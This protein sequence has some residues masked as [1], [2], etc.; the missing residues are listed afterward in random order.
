MDD[1]LPPHSPAITIEQLLV[2]D[3]I[4][5]AGSFSAAARALRRTQSAVSYH[6]AA[7]EGQLGVA[8]FDRSHRLPTLTVAGEAMLVHARRVLS[9]LN[10]LRGA[11][12]ALASGLEPR[13]FLAVNTLFPA[14]VLGEVM[15]ELGVRFPSV[16][17]TTRTSASRE[18]TPNAIREGRADLGV[19]SYLD[20]S[21]E[22]VV[23]P[24]MTVEL[25][26]VVAPA[27]P[28]A[29]RP[30]P[31]DDEELQE[32][33]HIMLSEDA[34]P[35]VED[36]VGF[37]STRRWRVNQEFLRRALLRA[38]LGWA[39]MPRHYVAED[40]AQGTLVP[41]SA[42]RWGN[43]TT[44]VDLYVARLR[45]RPLGPVGQWLWQRL[46]AKDE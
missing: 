33:V 32:H 2:F 24:C 11:S 43:R 28:L 23:E 18:D 45:R 44:T 34:R 39:R 8:L 6:V 3:A 37:P 13:I 12:R 10:E 21:E 16:D 46:V 9:S 15:T 14:E 4:A 22:F 29:G 19:I 1:G 5:E 42:R 31:V 27:H 38:G 40:L 36:V 7:L 25:V 30:S 17:T 26:P 20:R 35:E 41:L